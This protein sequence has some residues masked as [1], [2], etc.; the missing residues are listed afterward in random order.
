MNLTVAVAAVLAEQVGVG[1]IAWQPAAVSELARMEGGR[2]TLLTEKR[3]A[4]CQQIRIH[5]AMR[6]VAERAVFGNRRVFKQERPA[7]FSMTLKAG[8]IQ[9]G[10]DQFSLRDRPVRIMAVDTGRTTFQNRM[11]RL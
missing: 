6:T 1:L 5:G 8:V 11:P 10:F 7:F 4:H 9:R 3:A 2:V